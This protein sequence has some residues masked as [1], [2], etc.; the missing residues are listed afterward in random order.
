MCPR[1]LFVVFVSKVLEFL[2]SLSILRKT[3]G[4][5]NLGTDYAVMSISSR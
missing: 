4:T 2:Q 5:P 3:V 1:K